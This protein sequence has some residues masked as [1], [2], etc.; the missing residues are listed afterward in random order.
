MSIFGGYTGW[1]LSFLVV[2]ISGFSIRVVL[3]S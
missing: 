2:S 1:K 3:A